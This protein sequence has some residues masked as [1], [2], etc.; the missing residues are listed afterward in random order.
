MT[1]CTV[2]E[3]QGCVWHGCP[4]C[5]TYREQRVPGSDSSMDDVF[6][7]TQ[8]KIT[9]LKTDYRVVEMWECDFDRMLKEQE[10]VNTYVKSLNW[11][12]P[13]D[14]RNAFFGGRT[15]AICLNY[16]AKER[17]KIK[18]IDVCSLYPW[19]NKYGS[20]PVGH[21]EIITENFKPWHTYD[22]FIYCRV[23]PPRGLYHPVLP[24]RSKNKLLFPL[25]RTCGE[26]RQCTPCRHTDAER[27]MEGTW[28]SLEF[29][30]S[31]RTG[32]HHHRY[33]R[34]VAL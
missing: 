16:E 8:K 34:S 15:N 28:I 25:C 7:R 13:L 31:R 4:R 23:L 2:Y 10:A 27:A 6:H 18:Y 21:P 24:Y 19:V 5:Y 20:Y 33:L 14:P 3:F 26:T 30:G 29:K 22:G 32:I 12:E 11:R 17:E 1:N 9:S